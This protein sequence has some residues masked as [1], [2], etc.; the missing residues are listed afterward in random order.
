MVAAFL[1]KYWELIIIFLLIADIVVQKTKWKGDDDILA[2]IKSGIVS[3][4]TSKPGKL[5]MIFIGLLLM[6]LLL[7]G[8]AFAAPFLVCDPQTNITEYIIT[9][10]INITVP[11]FDL[12]DGT[13]RLQYDLSGITEGTFNLQVKAKNIWGE[14]VA[15]PF[16]FVKALPAAPVVI[17]IE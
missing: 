8:Q 9:G 14:S 3:L 15:V 11:A 2:M 4:F 13:V 7:V 6:G 16:D 12:G 1:I 17:R 5:P 10:D